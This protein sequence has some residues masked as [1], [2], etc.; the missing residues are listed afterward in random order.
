M[1][2]VVEPLTVTHCDNVCL[3]WVTMEKKEYGIWWQRCEITLFYT[4]LRQYKDPWKYCFQNGRFDPIFNRAVL[5]SRCCS[6]SAVPMTNDALMMHDQVLFLSGFVSGFFNFKTSFCPFCNCSTGCFKKS[7]W[8]CDRPLRGLSGVLYWRRGCGEHWAWHLHTSDHRPA[9]ATGSVH[10]FSPGADTYQNSDTSKPPQIL[11]TFC[12]QRCQSDLNST[13]LF[14][15][16]V[17]P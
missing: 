7:V 14:T 8:I 1:R 10:L 2:F 15:A 6:I 12:D 3:R 11:F 17:N 4:P 13:R 9:S 16:M 5:S